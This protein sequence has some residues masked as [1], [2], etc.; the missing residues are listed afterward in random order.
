M[1]SLGNTLKRPLN[2]STPK[3]LNFYIYEL[4]TI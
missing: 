1:L 2:F 3:L 4:D